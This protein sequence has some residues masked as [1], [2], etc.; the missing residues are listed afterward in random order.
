MTHTQSSVAAYE[1]TTLTAIPGVLEIEGARIQLLDLPGIIE[2]A[3]S[4]RG[5]GRQVVA[6]AK[7]AD[8]ILFVLDVNKASEQR[9]LLEIELEAIGIRLNRRKPDV[10]LKPKKAGG[11]SI[12]TTVPLTKLD[13]KT[14]R[15]ILAGNK[16]HNMDVYIREDITVDEF[17]DVLIGNRRYVN[18]IYVYNKID[19]ISMEEVD[20]IA[21]TPNSVVISC[22]LELNLDGLRKAIWEVRNKRSLCLEEAGWFLI[23]TNMTVETSSS[24]WAYCEFSPNHE[25]KE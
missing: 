12:S 14:I 25:G 5:R 11:V 19:T 16:L 24:N 6:V 7:T 8:L 20:R 22:E 4:G 21:R 15:T 13:E 2:G 1:Y 3:A 9:R 10:L 23:L 17:I 18:C